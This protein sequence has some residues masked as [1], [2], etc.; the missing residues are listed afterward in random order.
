MNESQISEGVQDLQIPQFYLDSLFWVH[1]RFCAICI[2]VTEFD[3]YDKIV[4]YSRKLS[5]HIYYDDSIN[6]DKML[7]NTTEIIDSNQ[8][9]RTQTENI[10]HVS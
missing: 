7:K 6:F 4:V 9:T 8:S 1:K 2:Y 10:V 5:K 3:I